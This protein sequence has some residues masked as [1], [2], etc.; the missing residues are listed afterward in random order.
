MARRASD[1]PFD[2]AAA[3]EAMAESVLVTDSNLEPPGPTV[4][5]ANPAFERMTG[6]SRREIV[7]RSPRVLQGAQTDRAVFADLR[8]TLAAGRPWEGQCVNYRKDGA[9]F[10]MQWSIVPLAGAHGEAMFFL[11]V[12]RDVTARVR[13]E[14]TAH[15]L[16]RYFPPE[17]AAMLGDRDQPFGPVRR[18]DLAVLFVDI[19]GFTSLAEGMPPEQVIELLRAFHGRAE[20]AIFAHRGIVEAYIGDAVVA[21]F[22][23]PEPDA[24]NAGDAL[25]CAAALLDEIDAWN[26]TAPPA[27]GLP[28]E[29]G[30]GVHYGPVVVGD[31]GTERCMAYTIIGDTVN[32][33]ARLQQLTR[34]EGRRLV[35]S[36]ALVARARADERSPVRRL[37]ARLDGPVAR[38]VKGRRAP[39]DIHTLAERGAIEGTGWGP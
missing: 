25:L 26:R 24:S 8:A 35:V 2:A 3:L 21:A 36:D 31:V 37:L 33:A 34:A 13:A 18:L 14:R 6:W 7:G 4:V 19:A 1:P 22:G 29:I 15:N 9:A 12:Q 27:D 30:I 32:A 17:I 20:A 39:L 16:A 38:P 10:I 28:I 5:Y 23:L 11:A